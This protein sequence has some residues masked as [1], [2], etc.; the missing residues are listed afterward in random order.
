MRREQSIHSFKE[1][2][3]NKLVKERI[4]RYYANKMET[5][6][7]LIKYKELLCDLRPPPPWK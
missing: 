3:T 7:K 6:I 2:V 4:L 5:E 1:R